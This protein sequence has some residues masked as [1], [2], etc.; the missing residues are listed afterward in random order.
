MDAAGSDER[1]LR[2]TDLVVIAEIEATQALE[3]V[4]AMLEGEVT[5]E[6]ITMVEEL[7]RGQQAQLTSA[8]KAL[9]ADIMDARRTTPKV[10]QK[11]I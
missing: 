7:L 11:E 5:Q 6:H 2:A 9:A 10:A 1:V 4:G 3:S 8:H